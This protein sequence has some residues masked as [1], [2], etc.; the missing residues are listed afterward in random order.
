MTGAAEGT[1]QG[2][3]SQQLPRSARQ[4][5][6]RHSETTRRYRTPHCS[7]T[8]QQHAIVYG[9]WA[10]WAPGPTPVARTHRPCFAT[11]ARRPLQAARTQTNRNRPGHT[12]HPLEVPSSWPVVVQGSEVAASDKPHR[13]WHSPT[14]QKSQ[15]RPAPFPTHSCLRPERCR[16]GRPWTSEAHPGLVAV[17]AEACVQ[18]A[19]AACTRHRPYLADSAWRRAA[20]QVRLATSTTRAPMKTQCSPPAIPCSHGPPPRRGGRRRRNQRHGPWPAQPPQTPPPPPWMAA[21]AAAAAARPPHSHPCRSPRSL[22][23]VSAGAP[24]SVWSPATETPTARR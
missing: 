8:S 17:A 9:G 11:R 5:D 7:A 24:G 10:A 12:E 16:H 18:T 20:G 13:R 23:G 6:A 19:L 22:S 14:R 3:W 4:P 21:A 15:G 1:P 2:N